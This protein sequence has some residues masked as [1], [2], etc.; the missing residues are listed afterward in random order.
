MEE[1][2]KSAVQSF[3]E[4]TENEQLNPFETEV[5]DPFATETVEEVVE[6]KEEKPIPFHKDPKLERYLSK[7][8]KEIE[9]RLLAQLP[10]QETV[11]E[12][13]F[14]DVVDSF[15]AIIGNDTPEKV[16]ALNS[17]KRALNTVDEKATNRAIEKLN[18]INQEQEKV[19]KEA[20]EQ[21]ISAFEDIEESYD[22][23]LTSSRS[24]KLRQEF[25]SFVERIAPKDKQGNIVD[26][27]DMTSAWETFSEIKKANKVPS[28]AK[29]L[30]SRS[31]SRSTETTVEQPKKISWEAVD[32]YMDTLK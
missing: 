12:D 28:R 8:E 31:L 26:Y 9:A 14:Q 32:E 2:E 29:E 30:A 13:E 18:E 22:V 10:R 23:D 6:E 24:T 1:K 3:L 11:E 5:K 21:L 7:R 15:T 20:E 19:D 17:L 4:G 16:N 25:V 27:P